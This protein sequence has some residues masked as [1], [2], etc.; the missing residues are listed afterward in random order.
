MKGLIIFSRLEPVPGTMLA[1]VSALLI[2]PCGCTTKA[3]AKAD[4]RAAYMAGQQQAL[5]RALQSRSSVSILGPVRNPLVTWTAGLTLA[6]AL[7]AADYYS[8]TDPKEILIVR[9]GQP[10][11]VDPKQLLAGEDIPLEAGDVVQIRP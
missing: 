3:K 2:L 7:V 9:N 11:N 4:A 6:Q 1:M 8:R 5:E 10:L